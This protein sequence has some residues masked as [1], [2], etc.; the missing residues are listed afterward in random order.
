MG[1]QLRRADEG[2]KRFL[3][4]ASCDPARGLDRRPRR[5]LLAA[6]V[7]LLVLS[8]PASA[9]AVSV[10]ASGAEPLGW[11]PTAELRYGDRGRAV[12]SLQRRLVTLGYLERG[13]IDG[14][15][16]KETWDA[17]VALQGWEQ[18]HRDGDVC[19]LSL[20]ATPQSL[21]PLNRERK[22]APGTASRP[23]GPP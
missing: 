20:S 9:A 21:N 14:I 16:G 8:G 4:D 3:P 22:P 12:A 6:I 19:V 17:V 10:A 15:F 1:S 11:A 5:T 23:A 2:V 13:W 7:V 18:I